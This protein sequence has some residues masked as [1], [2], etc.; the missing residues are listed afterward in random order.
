[1]AKTLLGVC[2]KHQLPLDARG[3]CQ[4]CRLSEMPSKPPPAASSRWVGVALAVLV[5]GGGAALAYAMVSRVERA[6]PERG[7]R[8]A[9]SVSNAAVVHLREP[10][11]FERPSSVP[12]PPPPPAEG[13]AAVAPP[14]APVAVAP[15]PRAR[16]VSEQEAQEALRQVKIEVY[17]TVWCGSCRRAREYLDY[18]GIPYAEYDI[19]EDALANERLAKL[20]PRKSIPTFEIDGIVQVGFSPE[21]LESRINQAVSRRLRSTGR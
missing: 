20:N 16:E 9:R 17:T 2:E 13:R 4:L 19:D 14:P 10:Q 15:S 11:S 21:N 6:E 7:V 5:L 12:L 3:N 8:G 1:M 18:N